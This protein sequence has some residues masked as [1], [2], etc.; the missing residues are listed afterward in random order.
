M[1]RVLAARLMHHP[2]FERFIILLILI[3]SVALAIDNPLGDP[4]SGSGCLRN[5]CC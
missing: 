1:L 5:A 2:M 4:S 3:S